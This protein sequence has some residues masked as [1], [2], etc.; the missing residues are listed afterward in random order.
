MIFSQKA[1][2]YKNGNNYYLVYDASTRR[3][4]AK[5][6]D[7]HVPGERGQQGRK[8]ILRSIQLELGARKHRVTQLNK[9]RKKINN[10]KIK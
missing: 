3:Y 9:L 5:L 4:S 7:F 2:V 1:Y 6:F 8:R 10:G